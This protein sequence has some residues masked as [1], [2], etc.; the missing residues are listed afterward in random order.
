MS[1]VIQFHSTGGPEVLQVEEIPDEIPGP[2]QI[3]IRVDA[4]G[5]NRA[6]C[7]LRRG[8]YAFNPLFP[9]KIGTEGA[10]TIE[11]SA[12]GMINVK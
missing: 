5:I 1:S 7:M 11:I 12:D 3:T 8:V 6:E 10:G 4:F 9:S 2:N